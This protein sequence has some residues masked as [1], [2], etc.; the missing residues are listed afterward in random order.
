MVQ[1]VDA[2]WDPNTSLAMLSSRG[3]SHS[4][5]TWCSVILNN[6]LQYHSE[7]IN[8]HIQG[9]SAGKVIIFLGDN[10]GHC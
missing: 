3:P 5:D 9:D 6:V 7:F 10:I 2:I 1:S 8:T 4:L